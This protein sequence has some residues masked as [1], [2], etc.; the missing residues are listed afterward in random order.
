MTDLDPKPSAADA[1]LGRPERRPGCSLDAL[2]RELRPLLAGGGHRADDGARVAALLRAYAA[3]E[4]SWRSYEV[5]AS[6]TYSRNLLWRDDD[7]EMLLLCWGEGHESP[8]HDHAGQQCWMAV[9]DGELEE[10]HFQVEDGE[11]TQ[12][13][14][15]SFSAGGVAFIHD[16]I[17]LH[18]IRPR[19]G[20]RGV[21]LHLYSDPIDAC[22]IFCPD[23]G[24]AEPVE[25]GYHSVRGT[26]CSGTDPARIRDAWCE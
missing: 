1:A 17:A 6:E 10:V 19:A 23:T 24:R 12:G 8:I 20:T 26:L 16:D 9:L 2:T 21:S 7:F 3:N 11:L 15:K 5:Y 14:V 18:L 22:R 13:R 25:V 4:E